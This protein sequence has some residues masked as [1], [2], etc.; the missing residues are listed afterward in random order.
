MLKIKTALAAI[1]LFF[2]VTAWASLQITDIEKQVS[3]T[4]PQGLH[5]NFDDVEKIK[6]LPYASKIFASGGTVVIEVDRHA[7]VTL[8][9]GQ[10]IFF[11]KRPIT[12]EIQIEKLVSKKKIKNKKSEQDLIPVTLPSNAFAYIP[13]SSKVTMLSYGD[14]LT[15]SV[16]K[17]KV[18]LIGKTGTVYELATGD[19]YNAEIESNIMDYLTP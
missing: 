19:S 6:E 8:K 11:T 4:Y 3:V 5:E 2:T 17:G 14:K 13:D 15:F 18:S 1:M 9:D 12:G 10:G 7:Y 16:K